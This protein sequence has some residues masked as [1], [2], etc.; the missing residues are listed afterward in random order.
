MAGLAILALSG[1]APTPRA[2]LERYLRVDRPKL[3]AYE[4]QLDEGG[5]GLPDATKA[6]VKALEAIHPATAQVRAVHALAL[7]AAHTQADA[8]ATF[9]RALAT[10]DYAL[11]NR[12]RERFKRAHAQRV[13]FLKQLDRLKAALG[14]AR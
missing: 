8:L 4:Q 7:K 1:C 10:S 5:K 14:L 13:A 11:G 12:A 6:Y 9:D 3:T 2:D